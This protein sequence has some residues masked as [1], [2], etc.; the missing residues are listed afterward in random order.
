MPHAM[1]LQCVITKCGSNLVVCTEYSY[2]N[3]EN[4]ILPIE[5]ANYSLI[6][7][8]TVHTISIV[9]FQYMNSLLTSIL[10]GNACN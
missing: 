5:V 2:L 6:D 9:A 3:S 8:Q 7:L 1:H 4:I 10:K